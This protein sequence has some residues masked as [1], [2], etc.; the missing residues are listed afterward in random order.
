MS[1]PACRRFRELLGVY[2]VGAIE[3]A[4]RSLLDEHLNGCQGCRDELAALAVLPALLHRI[5]V[6][7]AEQLAESGH[8]GEDQD[9]PA[10]Q[11]LAGLLGDVGARRRR[12]RVRTVLAAAAAVIVAVGGAVGVATALDQ[13]RPVVTSA[14][15]VAGAHRGDLWVTVRYDGSRGDTT[16]MW[17]RVHGISEWSQCRLYVTT[18][19]GR[20][21]LAGGW[22]VGPGGDG[23]WY[24]VRADVKAANVT[25]FT[26]TSAGKVL[27]RIPAT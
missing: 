27:L 6:A 22:L 16:A 18:A 13:P 17:V 15:E 2:V 8:G 14:L 4:E 1:D 24:P 12:R 23:L 5:P 26:L 20:S 25:A 19:D 7:E 11:V 9:D 21:H 3:P 10:P